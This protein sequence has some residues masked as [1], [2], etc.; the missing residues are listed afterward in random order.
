MTTQANFFEIG[1]YQPKR[2]HNIGTLWRSASQLGAHRLFTI[3]RRYRQQTSDVFDTAQTL[4]M[5]HYLNFD[6]FW[7]TR[8]PDV[9]IIAIET[10]GVP[11]R[12]FS[13]PPHAIYLLGAEDNGLPTTILEKCAI[14]VS[15][16]AVG[17]H[18]Y[19]VAVAGSIVMYHRQFL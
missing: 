3:G 19:N 4:P 6:E 12:S 11:L 1:V 15:L 13:H 9:P 2:E 17:W 7:A 10:G 5:R 16:E 8:P 14:R 18:S